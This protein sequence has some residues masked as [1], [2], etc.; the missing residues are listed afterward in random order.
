MR[1]WVLVP[2]LIAFAL[3]ARANGPTTPVTIDQ[4]EQMLAAARGQ[5]DSKVAR[6]LSG[7]ELTERVTPARLAR[8]LAEFPGRHCQQSLTELADASVFLP[9]PASDLPTAPAPSLEARRTIIAKA[10]EY[11]HN[12]LNRLP[13]FYATRTTVRFEDTPAHQTAERMNLASS[14]RSLRSSTLPSVSSGQSDYEPLHFAGGSKATVSYKD[15]YELRGSRRFDFTKPIAPGEGLATSG[16][17]GPILVIAVTDAVR[18]S[19]NW[20]HWEQGDKGLVAVFH[21]CVPAGHSHFRVGVPTGAHYDVAFPPYHGEMAIDPA[22]GNILHITVEAD[23]PPPNQLMESS[24]FVEYASISIGGTDYIC[25]VR[26]IALS[27]S[28]YGSTD[29]G[30]PG[31]SVPLQTQLNDVAFTDYHLFRAE[32]RILSGD[33]VHVAETPDSVPPMQPSGK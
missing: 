7:L 1:N 25:P 31:V 20:A 6:E 16:E 33:G 17:F 27:K 4:F 13:N 14:V 22:T 5:S 28:P 24:I 11:V 18:G 29:G 12:T 19:I 32:A 21:Y 2:L 26:S 15:G 10:I 9:L 23:L 30:Q 3:P 8:W